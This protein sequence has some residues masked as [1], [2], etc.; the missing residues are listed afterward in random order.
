SA[1]KHD[2]L[3]DLGAHT[4]ID[5]TRVD[6]GEAAGQVD[7]VLDT[8]GAEHAR[9]SA[10]LLRPG[11]RFVS[12]MPGDLTE[13]DAAAADIRLSSLLVRPSAADLTGLLDRVAAGSLRVL[14]DEVLP[15]VEARKAHGLVQDGHVTGKVVL[16]P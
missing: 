16:V 10:G 7:V 15:L 6:Y 11:G 8:L 14:V 5:H 2:L 13:E 12:V 1:A 9:R 3:R 4:L